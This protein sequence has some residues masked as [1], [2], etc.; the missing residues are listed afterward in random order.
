MKKYKSKQIKIIDMLEELLKLPI[1]KIF[2]VS[3]LQKKTKLKFNG[4]YEERI[5]WG[6]Y[7]SYHTD[8]LKSKNKRISNLY[9]AE[10]TIGL[11]YS[12][13]LSVY[14]RAQKEACDFKI[15]I[16]DSGANQLRQI[17]EKLDYVN[18]YFETSSYLL[19]NDQGGF[20]YGCKRI[21]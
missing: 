19:D 14:I 6:K 8:D 9:I 4:A 13:C 21:Q 17:A 5:E 3:T 10:L 16:D 20:F 2:S 11:D 15:N 1:G 7:R 12:K 18:E